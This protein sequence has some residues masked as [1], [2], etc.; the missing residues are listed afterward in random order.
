MRA[1]DSGRIIGNF[2]E[3]VEITK[4]LEEGQEHTSH[5]PH[6]NIPGTVEGVTEGYWDGE[7]MMI[8]LDCPNCSLKFADPYIGIRT[9]PEM[10]RASQ[11]CAMLQNSLNTVDGGH[12]IEAKKERDAFF[13]EFMDRIRDAD[14]ELQYQ[15][16][17]MQRSNASASY[18]WQP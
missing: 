1:L 14:S 6:C 9:A 16:I 2:D 13:Q 10:N 18:E 7:G 4:L 3:G 5:C 12:G 15:I 11:I 17:I 8:L